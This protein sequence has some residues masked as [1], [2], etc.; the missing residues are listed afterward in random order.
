MSAVRDRLFGARVI[1]RQIRS[2]M[3]R[4][5]YEAGAA[6]NRYVSVLTA[7]SGSRYPIAAALRTF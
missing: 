6:P 4:Y 5:S 7:I 3:R 2:V 1:G